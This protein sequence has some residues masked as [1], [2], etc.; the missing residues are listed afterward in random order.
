MIKN[1]IDFIFTAI[2]EIKL[3][4]RPTLM[5]IKCHILLPIKVGIFLSNQFLFSPKSVDFAG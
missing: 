4:N 1:S 2:D 5:G 3:E